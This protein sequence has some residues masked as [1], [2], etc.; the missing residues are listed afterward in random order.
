MAF[1]LCNHIVR[2]QPRRRYGHAQLLW[3]PTAPPPAAVLAMS[4]SVFMQS[5]LGAEA[6]YFFFSF[7]VTLSFSFFDKVAAVSPSPVSVSRHS[8]GVLSPLLTH[9]SH[10]FPLPS[11][12]RSSV[13]LPSSAQSACILE[14][15]RDAEILPLA[16]A[17]VNIVSFRRAFSFFSYLLSTPAA[18]AV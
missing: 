15:T 17:F 11:N 7:I 14:A 9:S 5:Q 18:I 3:S 2:G 12:L 6:G 4:S 16:R 1:L 10:D 8:S 13:L